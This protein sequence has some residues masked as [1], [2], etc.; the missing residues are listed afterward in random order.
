MAQRLQN[1]T[2]AQTDSRP[3]YLF[4]NT[5]ILENF[6]PSLRQIEWFRINIYI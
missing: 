2:E 4:L 6:I 1:Q 3:S 5:L